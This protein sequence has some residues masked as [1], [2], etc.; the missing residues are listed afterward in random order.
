MAIENP[1]LVEAYHQVTGEKRE[2]PE[3]W[4]GKNSPFPGQWGKSAPTHPEPDAPAVPAKNASRE[5][6]VAHAIAT[7]ATEADV[8]GKSRDELAE[9]YGKEG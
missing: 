5:T 3:H 7:G 2:V 1:D 9:T 8:E 4:L 6:W